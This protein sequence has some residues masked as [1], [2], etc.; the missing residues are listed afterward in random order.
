MIHQGQLM[1]RGSAT[2]IL[3][4]SRRHCSKGSPWG[5]VQFIPSLALVTSSA[6]GF[7][8]F[9]IPT[10]WAYISNQCAHG[11]DGKAFTHIPQ[12]HMLPMIN[13]HTCAYLCFRLYFQGGFPSGA[14]GKESACQCR[15][16][17]RCR[18]DSWV[19]KIPWRRVC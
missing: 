8:P 11:I 4:L 14:S 9:C 19:R 12:T 16:C 1:G 17:K 3:L 5:S 2:L 13:L 7:Y 10:F 6:I 18:F 15:G